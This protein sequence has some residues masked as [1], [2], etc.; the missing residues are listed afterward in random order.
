[1][2]TEHKTIFRPLQGAAVGAALLFITTCGGSLTP[3]TAPGALPGAAARGVAATRGTPAR[4]FTYTTLDDQS[5]PTF[6]QLL[7]INRHDVISGY[8]G[9][10]APGHPNKGYIIN[11]PYGQGNYANENFP[12]SAQTQVTAINDKG[13]LAGFWGNAK[14]TNKGWIMWNGVFTS[15]VDPNTPKMVGSV[16]QLLGLN[17]AGI[18]VG[19]YTDAAGKNHPY[20][21]DQ[22]TGKFTAL[23]PPAAVSSVAS[24]INS[25]GDVCGISTSASKTTSSFLL[26]G[27][28]YSA[29]QFPN[30]SDTQAFGC[31]TKDAIV[32]SYLDGSGVMHG[33]LVTTPLTHARWTSIDDPNGVGSTVVNGLNDALDLVGFYTDAAGNTDGMLATP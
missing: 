11:P 7:G 25:L 24:G 9:S 10:G 1:M 28:H 22:K 4:T 16:N 15:Y 8:F 30:G 3:A 12:G 2:S 26:K 31:N 23:H 21:L 6:N 33:F 32:G 19:F 27:G 13:D 5:D 17:D 20:E 18:A 29:L 14:N